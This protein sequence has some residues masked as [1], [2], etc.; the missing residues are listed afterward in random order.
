MLLAAVP[1]AALVIA[2]A[3]CAPVA[4]TSTAAPSGTPVAVGTAAATPTPTPTATA[5]PVVRIQTSCASL[6]ASPDVA[7]WA[8][9]RAVTLQN[10]GTGDPTD[11]Y[12]A[13]DRQR[14]ILTCVWGGTQKTDEDY[15]QGLTLTIV[16]DAAAEFESDIAN[17]D[18]YLTP[19]VKDTAGTQSAYNC[20]NEKPGF[21]CNAEMLVGETWVGASL[22]TDDGLVTTATI[23]S[24]IQNILS[25]LATKLAAAPASTA[26][27]PIPDSTLPGFCS[28][29]GMGSRLQ[30]IL[31]S[32]RLTKAGSSPQ[33]G[34]EDLSAGEPTFGSCNWN[35]NGA[36][37]TRPLYIG[38][39]ILQGGSWLLPVLTADLPT[40]FYSGKDAPITIPGAT[41][42]V[43]G[44]GQG[45]CIITFS[46]GDDAYQVNVDDAGDAK[47]PATLAAL[48]KL[49]SAP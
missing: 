13:A 19:A 40:P 7:N 32:A 48:V 9:N 46:V 38:A 45:Q 12:D 22:N 29:P 16:P 10:D 11:I 2:L 6:F 31:G 15:D 20:Q 30:V 8:N 34:A 23:K 42:A 35:A 28:E 41:Q 18:A 14:G 24:R 25:T 27:W 17:I 1:I 47:T 33:G 44:C 36:S 39:S 4:P 5:V 26:A 37:A 49:V 43:M 3:G 21:S